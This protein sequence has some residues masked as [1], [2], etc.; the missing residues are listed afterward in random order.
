MIAPP[1][2]TMVAQH[3]SER[4][5]LVL[6]LEFSLRV[7]S[8]LQMQSREHS[9][10]EFPFLLYHHRETYEHF[11]GRFDHFRILDSEHTLSQAILSLFKYLIRYICGIKK[12]GHYDPPCFRAVTRFNP[13]YR[14]G[15][16][17]LRRRRRQCRQEWLRWTLL[18]FSI[19]PF[20]HWLGFLHGHVV[21]AS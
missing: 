20:F 10:N 4:V 17:R 6:T 3:Q 12:E 18:V 7:L 16:R 13:C 2:R 15:C 8:C 21:S 19:P 1:K 5:F 11:L 14:S 9:P